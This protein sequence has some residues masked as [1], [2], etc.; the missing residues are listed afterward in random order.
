MGVGTLIPAMARRIEV[1]PLD[2]FVPYARNARTHS[3]DQVAQIAASIIEF[4]FTNPILVDS[5]DGI[6]AGHGRLLAARKLGMAEVPVI[7]L[8]NLSPTQRRAYILADNKLAL[9]AGW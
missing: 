3:A 4:G 8:D 9:N 7:V 6:I 1:W 5:A 2:R